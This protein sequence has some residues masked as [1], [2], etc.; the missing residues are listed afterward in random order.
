MFGTSRYDIVL[1][2]IYSLFLFSFSFFFPPPACPPSKETLEV[3]PS[4]P[5]GILFG[6]LPRGEKTL[7][8]S[9]PREGGTFTVTSRLLPSLVRTRQTLVVAFSTRVRC[10]KEK[11][12]RGGTATFLRN[13]G[14]Y[15]NGSHYSMLVMCRLPH[16]WSHLHRQYRQHPLQCS[17]ST[18]RFI[19]TEICGPI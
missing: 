1:T 4:S 15:G 13:M 18:L 16:P 19:S 6:S 10:L 5:E 17:S 7:Q 2:F 12:F 9:P 3:L 8:G 14:E 11:G